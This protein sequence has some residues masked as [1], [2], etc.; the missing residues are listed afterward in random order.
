M[1]IACPKKEVT[2]YMLVHMRDWSGTRINPAR[3][4]R[5]LNKYSFCTTC[6]SQFHLV[7][8]K[9]VNRIEN[10]KC[11]NGQWAGRSPSL[12]GV[13]KVIAG[14]IKKFSKQ[15]SENGQWADRSLSNRTNRQWRHFVKKMEV[16][17]RTEVKVG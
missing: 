4:C 13:R 9:S 2:V 12:Y 1:E 6:A 5:K 7:C 14:V 11:E 17:T 15:I 16:K 8:T 3:R 10:E